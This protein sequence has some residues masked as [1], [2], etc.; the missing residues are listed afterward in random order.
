MW[1]ASA[2]RNFETMNK[3]RIEG[4]ALRAVPTTAMCMYAVTRRASG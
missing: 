2:E 1:E 4:V 3:N